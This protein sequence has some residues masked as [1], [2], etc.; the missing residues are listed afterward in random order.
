MF[1]R[2]AFAFIFIF[3]GVSISLACSCA[4]FSVREKVRYSESVFTGELVS[5]KALEQT[6]DGFYPDEAVFKVEKQWKGKKQSQITALAA[7]D[8]PGMCG[9]LPLKVGEKY[10]IY[11]RKK[12]GKL[13]IQR[14]CPLSMSLK[15]ADDEIKKLDDF[16][17]RFLT[18]T[19]PYPKF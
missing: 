14:D 8:S 1:C 17:S 13:L 7:F 15:Y 5:F 18:K 6:F 19:Y 2:F 12:K 11:A 16:W 3:F 10:L 4:D 9:D